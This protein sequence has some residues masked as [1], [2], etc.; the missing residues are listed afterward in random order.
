MVHL[1]SQT[2]WRRG[3]ALS[4]AANDEPRHAAPAQHCSSP[5]TD[6]AAFV[7]PHTGWYGDPAVSPLPS[8]PAQLI[9]ARTVAA[10][11]SALAGLEGGLGREVS[12]MRAECVDLLVELDAR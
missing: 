3:D 12:S 6:P 9:D 7:Q 11:D 4:R 1:G 8:L 2:A 5:P 10:A